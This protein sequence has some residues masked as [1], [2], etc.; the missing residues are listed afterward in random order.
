ME[1]NIQELHYNYK[2][3]NIHVMEILE[4]EERNKQKKYLK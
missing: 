2:T 3:Y 4:K 1:K